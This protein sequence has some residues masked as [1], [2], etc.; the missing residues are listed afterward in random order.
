MKNEIV[1]EKLNNIFEKA[2]G[3]TRGVDLDFV[4]KLLEQAKGSLACQEDIVKV[5]EKMGENYNVFTQVYAS[6]NT[7][8]K[9]EAHF[10]LATYDGL[11]HI[12]KNFEKVV[13]NIGDRNNLLMTVMI[14]G[15]NSEVIKSVIAIFKD[16]KRVICFRVIVSS[17]RVGQIK[18]LEHAICGIKSL[19]TGYIDDDA[20]PINFLISDIIGRAVKFGVWAGVCVYSQESET[21]LEYSIGLITH[22]DVVSRLT[23][24]AMYH[25]GG[26]I[27]FMKT[28]LFKESVSLA[29]EKNILLGPMMA[30][31]A[32]KHGV[33]PF[34]DNKMQTEHPNRK[35]F[36]DWAYMTHKYFYSW[37]R[38]YEYLNE[39]EKKSFFY[40]FKSNSEK[41]EKEIK[42]ILDA[43]YVK[44]KFIQ[45]L[46]HL[47]LED[48]FFEKEF[49]HSNRLSYLDFCK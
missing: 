37:E 27:T 45:N 46:R 16:K 31:V 1:K 25:G 49:R 36:S 13:E 8:E 23:N 11:D 34:S 22:S 6:N 7:R 5:E 9:Y 18:A 42:K 15:Y 30:C 32:Y 3:L 44:Y 19:V 17:M 26:G 41:R 20:L 14:D 35:I 28:D 43:D 2:T 29:I 12:R 24:K 21:L 40:L 4:S 48:D 39:E 33:T 38:A 47:I 10:V